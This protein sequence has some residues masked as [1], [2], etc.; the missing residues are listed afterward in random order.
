MVI[1]VESYQDSAAA[2]T[3]TA[4]EIWQGNQIKV[5]THTHS[6]SITQSFAYTHLK[7]SFVDTLI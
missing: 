1:N 2:A 5:H 4:W 7:L 3:A 6:F